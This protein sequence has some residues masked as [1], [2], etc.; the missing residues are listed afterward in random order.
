MLYGHQE[1]RGLAVPCPAK[2]P[3]MLKSS[4][5]GMTHSLNLR[6]QLRLRSSAR[7]ISTCRRDQATW[8]KTRAGDVEFCLLQ[9]HRLHHS[10]NPRTLFL[11]LLIA[12]HSSCHLSE[13]GK[14]PPPETQH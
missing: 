6:L 10:L 9:H 2:G 5:F 8:H 3:A 4:I 1:R 12:Q 11:T 14:S 7:G 13:T